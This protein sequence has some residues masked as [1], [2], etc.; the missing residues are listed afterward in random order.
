MGNVPVREAS[1]YAGFQMNQTIPE[2]SIQ[3]TVEAA[4]TSD[5]REFDRD[6]AISKV[7]TNSPTAFL[8]LNA[9]CNPKRFFLF[10]VPFNRRRRCR[11][12]CRERQE[13][14]FKKGSLF[15]GDDSGSRGHKTAKEEAHVIWPQRV[16]RSTEMSG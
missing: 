5:G 2:T 6:F 14:A 15:P 16:S 10:F 11:K 4:I 1:R 8:A 3:H 9:P 13:K 12:D 7:K